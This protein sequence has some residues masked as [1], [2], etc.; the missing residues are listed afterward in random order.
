MDRNSELVSRGPQSPSRSSLACEA[1]TVVVPTL[2]LAQANTLLAYVDER[3]K[4]GMRLHKEMQRKSPPLALP[5]QDATTGNLERMF[6]ELNQLHQNEVGQLHTRISQLET[7]LRQRLS[8]ARENAVGCGVDYEN[9]VHNADR[10][11]VRLSSHERGS[12]SHSRNLLPR[13]TGHGNGSR[14]PRCC[15]KRLGS[16]STPRGSVP[17]PRAPS[18]RPTMASARPLWIAAR[19]SAPPGPR[20]RM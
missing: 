11:V 19:R 15:G 5:G 12:N 3:S 1:L 14:N 13:S 16:A 17:G 7:E 2:P 20:A 4:Q 6:T 10:E 18:P 8:M 9:E